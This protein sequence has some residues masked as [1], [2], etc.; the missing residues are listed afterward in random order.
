MADETF[1]KLTHKELFT[2]F[3][4]AGVTGFGGVLPVA[5][6]MIVDKRKWMTQAQ[7]NDLFSLCQFLPGANIVNFAFALGVRERGVSGAAVAILGLLGAPMG[8]VLVLGALYARY[9]A[10][11]VARHALAGLAAAA[12]GLV[13]GTALKISA[14]VFARQTNIALAVCVCA[15]VLFG[16]FSLHTTMALALPVSLFFAWKTE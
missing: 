10:M 3:F 1:S 14:P 12:A 2:G 15:L 13:V 11:P 9:G 7:F 8:I 6:R 16:H 4:E 5:R